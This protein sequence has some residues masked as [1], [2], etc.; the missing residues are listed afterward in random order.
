MYGQTY[1]ALD[2]IKKSR[3]R[4]VMITRGF[5]KIPETADPLYSE[6]SRS[7]DVPIIAADY[8]NSLDELRNAAKR[9][10]HK[11][12]E[13]VLNGNHRVEF[14]RQVHRLSKDA[15]SVVF[16]S[17]YPKSGVKMSRLLKQVFGKKIKT[18]VELHCLAEL[19]KYVTAEEARNNPESRMNFELEPTL[20]LIDSDVDAFVAVSEA[21]KKSF[22]DLGVIPPEKILVNP[23]G[24]DENIYLPKDDRLTHNPTGVKGDFI[25]GYV[26]RL[27]RVKGS[28]TLR[29]IIEIAEHDYNNRF[30]FVFANTN[31]IDR[32]SR[33]SFAEYVTTH[34]PR[35]V[36]EDRIKFVVDVSKL[37]YHAGEGERGNIE[38][39]Y[40]NLA[41]EDGLIGQR[42]YGGIT[43]EPAQRHLDCYIQASVSEA[44]GLSLIEAIACGIPAIVT[45]VG[46][47]V[48]V[49][50]KG[51]GVVIN[52]TDDYGKARGFYDAMLM[53]R[54]RQEEYAASRI[55]QDF[56]R[57]EFTA[58]RMAEMNDSLYERLTEVKKHEGA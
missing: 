56:L 21:T 16:V 18:V 45:N 23:N 57:R 34:A 38:K 46:G 28:D 9:T 12:L 44:I 37:V 52:A 22:T 30:G 54:D 1:V 31:G 24:V 55:R 51:N 19:Y 2:L 26:G 36:A 49:I 8:V 42:L 35:L 15:E 43:T 53:I 41:K 27:D 50:M 29:K 58:S 7:M 5:S 3:F 4:N 32:D 48:E 13:D 47:M 6:M 39:Y 33:K 14:A 20:R 11:S 25:A 40:Q 10:G 17:H